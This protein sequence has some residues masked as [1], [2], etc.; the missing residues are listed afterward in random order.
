MRTPYTQIEHHTHTNE[1]L[2][3]KKKKKPAQTIVGTMRTIEEAVHRMK[4]TTIHKHMNTKR[5]NEKP[6]KMK[7]PYNQN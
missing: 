3:L 1:N 6:L 4:K 5:T 2:P 7:K